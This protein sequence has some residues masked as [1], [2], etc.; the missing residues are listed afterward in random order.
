MLYLSIKQYGAQYTLSSL[1]CCTTMKFIKVFPFSLFT[2]VPPLNFIHVQL[3]ALYKH[4]TFS[5]NNGIA[6]SSVFKEYTV[7]G[8][9]T[10][11]LVHIFVTTRFQCKK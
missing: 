2:P 7:V 5:Y 10:I 9:S 1:L 4:N 3:H 11:Y 6:M 8:G